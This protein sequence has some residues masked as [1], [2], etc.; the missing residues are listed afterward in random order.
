MYLKKSIFIQIPFTRWI[1][2]WK[3]A[4]ATINTI[5]RKS[6]VTVEISILKESARTRLF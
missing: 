3:F 5:Y 6:F 4:Y 2:L 1:H